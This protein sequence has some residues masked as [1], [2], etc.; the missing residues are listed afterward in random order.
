MIFTWYWRCSSIWTL[1]LVPAKAKKTSSHY[2]PNTP[3]LGKNKGKEVLII[4][5]LLWDDCSWVGQWSWALRMT[6]I[7]IILFDKHSLHLVLRLD[8]LDVY[9]PTNWTMI[10]KTPPYIPINFLLCNNWSACF[11]QSSGYICNGSTLGILRF[12]WFSKQVRWRRRHLMIPWRNY[13]K[14]KKDERYKIHSKII[15]KQYWTS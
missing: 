2:K 10:P 3:N 7:I 13:T 4:V 5:Q 14:T 9:Q 11:Q 15:Q 6:E 8:Q 1:I 12:Y